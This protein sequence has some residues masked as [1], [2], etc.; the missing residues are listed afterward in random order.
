M[1]LPLSRHARAFGRSATISTALLGL[2]LTAAPATATEPAFAQAA[3]D[4][5]A[6]QLPW[7][8][9]SDVLAATLETR[10]LAGSPAAASAATATPVAPPA[11]A[12]EPE[13]EH[14]VFATVAGLE[15]LEPSTEIAAIGFHEG[16]TQGLPLHPVGKVLSNEGRMTS[17]EDV[18]G[19]DYRILA[20]RGRGVG[21][22]TAVDIAMSEDL[23]VH[24]V[25][26]GTVVNVSD[27]SLYGRTNDVLI[28]IV[29][30]GYADVKVQVFH[31]RH[32]QV[33]VGDQVVAGE[34]VLARPRQLPFGSQIDRHVG[35]AGPHVHIQVV[36]A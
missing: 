35:K 6:P 27:Y 26:S 34:T 4:A 17:P 13:P 30:E 31:V 10:A 15:L 8:S 29:P 24:A 7:A 1:S 23:P 9:V 12:P 14:R 21:A 20:S 3:P 25:V 5:F 28:E 2:A 18:A 32:A 19:P 36:G 11:P 16:S 22:S 33:A